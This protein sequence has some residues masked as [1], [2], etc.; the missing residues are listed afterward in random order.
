MPM[1]PS[2]WRARTEGSAPWDSTKETAEA[3][4][5]TRP[6]SRNVTSE[7]GVI[8]N[9]VHQCRQSRTGEISCQC[10]AGIL[11]SARL[12]TFTP[13]SLTWLRHVMEDQHESGGN[14]MD[15][16]GKKSI[17]GSRSEYKLHDGRTPVTDSGQSSR[18]ARQ[19]PRR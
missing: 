1:M 19:Q 9:R 16:G 6:T 8:A 3:E 4:T 13:P 2:R 5:D 17:R 10:C 11:A 15:I 7:A 12:R 18:R 14:Q